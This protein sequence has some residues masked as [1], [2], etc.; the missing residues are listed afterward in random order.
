MSGLSVGLIGTGLMGRTHAQGWQTRPGV[1]TCVYA[2]DERART[3]AREFNLRPCASTE[4]LLD[5]VDIVDLCTPTPTHPDLAV[6]AARAGRHV[7]CEKP[8]ALT[9]AEADRIM[10]ACRTAGVRLF[11]AHVLR[12]FPQYRAAWDQVQAGNIGIPRVLRLSRVSSPPAPGSWLLD[13]AQSG[14]VPLDLMIHDLDFARWVA[15]EV[16]TVYAAGRHHGG[17]TM[18]QVTLSHISGAISLIEGGWAAPAGVFRTALDL[19]GT[20]GVIEWSSDAPAALRRHGPQPEPRQLG[21][22]L[23]ALAGDPYAAELLHAYQAIEEGLPFLVEPED[24]RA[25]LALSHAV[26]RSLASGQAVG[27]EDA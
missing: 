12:F 15:G 1:L 10:A 2:P 22:A 18:V 13:E 27:M 20:R 14:G 25:A 7:I 9:L 19:A 3:F 21:A 11:V 24:A 17:R 8:L 5:R 6:Q 16:N 26:R 4:E 23:P